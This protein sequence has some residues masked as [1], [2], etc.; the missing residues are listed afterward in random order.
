MDTHPRRTRMK[1]TGTAEALAAMERTK[2][3]EEGFRQHHEEQARLAD[4]PYN[5]LRKE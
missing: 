5:G 1:V 3:K 2:A 4:K